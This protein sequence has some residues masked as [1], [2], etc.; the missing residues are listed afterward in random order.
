LVAEFQESGAFSKEDYM[1]HSGQIFQDLVEFTACAR[2][3]VFFLRGEKN[4]FFSY[5]DSMTDDAFRGA[6]I[7]TVL[8]DGT[9]RFKVA[10]IEKLNYPASPRDLT[11]LYFF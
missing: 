7:Y 10:K 5:A 9:T 3:S 8:E 1:L 6:I 11:L 2:V 4:F